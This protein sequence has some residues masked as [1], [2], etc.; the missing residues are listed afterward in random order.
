MDHLFGDDERMLQLIAR[1]ECDKC[2]QSIDAW[3]EY[4]RWALA[5]RSLRQHG[6][7]VLY[8]TLLVEGAYTT[9]GLAELRSNINSI[10]E[11]GYRWQVRYFVIDTRSL[12]ADGSMAVVYNS[13]A[14]FLAAIIGTSRVTVD[15]PGCADNTETA[16]AIARLVEATIAAFPAIHGFLV[17]C[18]G[19]DDRL[20]GDGAVQKIS[21][22]SSAVPMAGPQWPRTIVQCTSGPS[23]ERAL[24]PPRHLPMR[25]ATLDYFSSLGIPVNE[26]VKTAQGRRSGIAR[27]RHAQPLATDCHTQCQLYYTPSVPLIRGQDVC[28]FDWCFLPLRLCA[29]SAVDQAPL[30]PP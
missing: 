30:S 18:G 13:V 22:C 26:V 27:C 24:A 25:L 23:P 21:Y 2:I 4:N 9:N 14:N 1:G 5:G 12:P 19:R 29:I 16:L 17:A 15:M 11:A 8:S 28:L 6:L 3:L 20:H 7:R 10:L